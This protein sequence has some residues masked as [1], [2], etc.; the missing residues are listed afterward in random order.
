[1]GLILALVVSLVVGGADL[2]I[3]Q[4]FST[5]GEMIRGW[6]SHGTTTHILLEIRI[7]RIL[8][9]VALGSGMGLA[10]LAAQTLFRN[11]LA[12]PYVLGVSNGSAVGAVVA[13]LLLVK[14]FGYTAVPVLSLLSGLGVGAAVFVLARRSDQ[15]GHALL[16]AGIAVSAFCSALTAGALYLAG[17]RLQ[18]LVFWLMGGLWLASWREVLLMAPVSALALVL[19][20]VL[21]PAMNV[22]LVGERS[23]GDLG[24]PVRRFQI[25]LLVTICLSTA[26]AVAVSGV[27]G[28]VGLIVPHLLRLLAGADHRV[29]VPASALGGALLLLVADTLAR[30][31]ASPA[32]VPVGI[33]TA[34]VGAP[35]FLWL[36][37]RRTTGGGWA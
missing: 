24:V 37:V 11:P 34:L 10:G 7:P 21:A 29:L 15:F 6:P 14:S 12:S 16:L 3:G 4:V 36:L 1:M 22:A 30:R 23:A 31:V 25:L 9:A 17:E 20:M 18:T 13:M 32:E 35:I 27:I 2:T 8:L 5:L 19:L 26:M 28:F 33:I